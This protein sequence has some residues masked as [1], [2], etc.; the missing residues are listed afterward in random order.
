[1]GRL[2]LAG[3]G[4]MPCA[5]C[6]PCCCMLGA[7]PDVAAPGEGGVVMP[8]AD[9]RPSPG[10]PAG[11]GGVITAAATDGTDDPGRGGVVA[12]P[13][14]GP[15]MGAALGLRAGALEGVC[16]VVDMPGLAD[17]GRCD[18]DGVVECGVAECGSVVRG[19]KCV[20]DG[21]ALTGRA[22]TGSECGAG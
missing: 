19:V 18:D 21:C 6:A 13:A 22:G 10:R 4:C 5:P 11:A 12:A 8:G 17:A 16:D 14:P 7:P 20:G 9:G 1:M 3:V 15:D 2:P